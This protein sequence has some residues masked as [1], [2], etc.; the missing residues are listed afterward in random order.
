[1][2]DPYTYIVFIFGE[3]LYDACGYLS[4]DLNFYLTTL[5]FVYNNINIGRIR[6]E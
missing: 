5:I 3:L 6:L 1:M 4:P 2:Y